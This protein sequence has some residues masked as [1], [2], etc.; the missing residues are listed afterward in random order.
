M[1][2]RSLSAGDS[3]QG[4]VMSKLVRR[5]AMRAAVALVALLATAPVAAAASLPSPIGACPDDTLGPFVRNFCF[6]LDA[7]CRMWLA[8]ECFT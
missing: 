3:V 7:L 1:G 2:R 4:K 8:V 6:F 5:K